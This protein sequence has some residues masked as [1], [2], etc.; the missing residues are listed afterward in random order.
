[1]NLAFKYQP[2][3][4]EIK[5][6]RKKDGKTVLGRGLKNRGLITK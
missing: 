2:V 1:M 6:V 5:N 3:E 4:N